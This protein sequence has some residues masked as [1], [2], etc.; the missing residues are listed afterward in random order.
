MSVRLLFSCVQL[1]YYQPRLLRLIINTSS[2]RL[3][4]LLLPAGWPLT[5]TSEKLFQLA[6]NK[7]DFIEIFRLGKYSPILICNI[8][9]SDLPGS[10]PG[11]MSAAGRRHLIEFLQM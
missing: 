10:S 7:L 11:L 8:L 3:L 9:I 2:S 1:N 5:G 6:K 4:L